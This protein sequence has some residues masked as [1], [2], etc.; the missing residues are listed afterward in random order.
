MNTVDHVICIDDED[1]SRPTQKC[2]HLTR[3][4]V[5]GALQIKKPFIQYIGDDDEIHYSSSSRFVRM[6]PEIESLN[7][8]SQ[9]RVVDLLD[10]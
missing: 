9:L 7:I 6:T 2:R 8:D 10:I 5:Y 3:G 4:K 1:Y